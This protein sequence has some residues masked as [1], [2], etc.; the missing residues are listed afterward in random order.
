MQ[1]ARL[2]LNYFR[3]YEAL[4]LRPRPGLNVIVG[5]NAQGK[6][7]AVEAIFFCAFSRSHRTARDAEL[8]NQGMSGG[9]VGLDVQTR[10]GERKQVF[11][12]RLQTQRSGELMG[13]LNVVMFSPEDLELVKGAPAERRRFLDM[14]LSQLRP[15][16]YY[17]IQQYNA[18]LK[19]RNALLKG[20]PGREC[21]QR[22]VREQLYVW[23]EQLAAAGA[24]VMRMRQEF[25]DSLST[26]A[27]DLHRSISGGREQ[28]A[29]SYAPSVDAARYGGTEREALQEALYASAL[30]DIR[31][32]F[33]TMGPHRDDLS[34]CLG[35]AP[36]R[37]FGSQGQQRTAALSL[38]LAEREI[39][40]DE[41]DEYPVLMLD[42]VLSELDAQRQAFVLN[43]IGGGQTL[44]TCC[45]DARIAERTGGRVLTVANGG[46]R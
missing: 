38:K 31:R 6:T 3:N 22:E 8:I 10:A 12:D 5:E 11:I 45:E 35:D 42:D 4:D 16:Y 14:E 13:V 43:R 17:K 44:I 20:E 18:A 41:F 33:T 37:V 30:D 21:S 32:G 2:K 23:D 36:V 34:V 15:A 1:I 27:R 46:I 7:N 25:V 9:Y 40:H 39:F 24:D 26:L 19:Q 29:V 28:L